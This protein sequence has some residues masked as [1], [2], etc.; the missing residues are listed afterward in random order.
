MRARRRG[1][2][3]ALH[4]EVAVLVA[5]NATLYEELDVACERVNRLATELMALSKDFEATS[6]SS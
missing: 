5:E 1:R 6:S 4:E 2:M 3:A